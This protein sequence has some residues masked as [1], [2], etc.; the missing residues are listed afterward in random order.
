MLE[1]PRLQILEGLVRLPKLVG[2][3]SPNCEAT[4]SQLGDW[5]SHAYLPRSPNC[6]AIASQLGD[7]ISHAHLPRSP[8]YETRRDA[9]ARCLCVWGRPAES[10]S[11]EH[12]RG[13]L[14]VCVTVWCM[15]IVGG[16]P[17]EDSRRVRAALLG[18]CLWAA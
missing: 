9:C 3:R 10:E 15:A 16:R 14:C 8:N 17:G 6:E 5:I 7:W 18:A 11:D 2:V 12:A 13:L 4:A 1:Q